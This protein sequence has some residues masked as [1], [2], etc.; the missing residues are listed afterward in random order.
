MHVTGEPASRHRRSLRFRISQLCRENPG[1]IAQGEFQGGQETRKGHIG[2]D[3]KRKGRLE[4][5]DAQA[6]RLKLRK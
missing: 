2:P 4:I 5:A 6:A 1:G 3:A